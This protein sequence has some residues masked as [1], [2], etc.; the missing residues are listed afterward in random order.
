MRRESIPM[1]L[2]TTA[3]TICEA[4]EKMALDKAAENLSFFDMPKLDSKEFNI[5][6]IHLGYSLQDIK[7]M[8]CHD[9]DDDFLSDMEL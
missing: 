1:P 3:K 8:D 6:L 2:K 4:A 7:D 5:A 9:I